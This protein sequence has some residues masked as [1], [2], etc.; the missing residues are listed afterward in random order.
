[1]QVKGGAPKYSDLPNLRLR[2]NRKILRP[3]KKGVSRSSRYVSRNAMDA[4]APARDGI[5]G[6]ATPVSHVGPRI[7]HGAVTA[8]LFGFGSEHA[9][10]SGCPG[11]DVRGRQKRVGLEASAF[12]R[13]GK[14]Q[15]T[16]VK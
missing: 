3:A 12:F 16:L 15:K 13:L 2:V 7:R 4:A 9:Q 5:T 1:M 6:R 14:S 11:R 8:V 10:A